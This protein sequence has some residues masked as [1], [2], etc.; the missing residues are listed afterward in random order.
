M[1]FPAIS[2]CIIDPILTL[3]LICSITGGKPD[4]SAASL[5]N[6]I[7]KCR[8]DKTEM[9]VSSC[10]NS[11]HYPIIHS[12][13]VNIMLKYVGNVLIHF[14]QSMK[15]M[16]NVHNLYDDLYDVLKGPPIRKPKKRSAN[17]NPLPPQPTAPTPP[18]DDLEPDDVPYKN[19]TDE[20]RKR[21]KVVMLIHY[22][23]F[24]I[25]SALIRL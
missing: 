25:I 9:I 5:D 19:D 24:N 8:E 13:P 1:I 15:V 2:L 3:Q 7:R 10:I 12:I 21:Y 14:L 16:A 6:Y 22:A 23:S 17:G 11:F 20:K 4:G 18:N